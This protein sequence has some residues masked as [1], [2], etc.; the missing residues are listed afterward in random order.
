MREL[1]KREHKPWLISD[2]DGRLIDFSYTKIGQYESACSVER[3]DSFSGLLDFYFTRSA[4]DDRMRQKSSATIKSMKTVRD[5]L[6]R[7][8]AIQEAELRETSK[9]EYNRESGDIITANLHLMKKGMAVLIADD[10][11]SDPVVKRKISRDPLKSPQQNAARYYKAYTK[12]KNAAVFLSRQIESGEKELLYIDSVLD[13][14][15]RAEGERDLGEVRAE[16]SEL[17]YIRA[18][19]KG[20]VR[21]TRSSPIEFKSGSGFKILVGRNNTQND[22]LTLKTAARTDIWLH[23]Q[24]IHGAHVIVFLEG[25][26]IDDA[27]LREAA[28]IAAFYSAAR[29]GGNVPVDYTLVKFVKKPSGSRPGMVIYT[30]QK[31]IMAQPDETLVE[32][33][34]VNV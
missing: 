25:R 34:R 19:S 15:G 31:T 14:I 26:S 2:L 8:L 9:R 7:K 23:T 13:Q 33:L 22:N 20:K 10:F 6:R 5:R 27:T 29:G 30:E 16:L 28:S 18:Q 1:L 12:A 24:K 32:R 11:Y 4:Q 17:G 3:Y 21:H